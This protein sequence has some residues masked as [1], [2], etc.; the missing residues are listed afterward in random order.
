[1]KRVVITGQG[2]IS[3]L[4]NTADALWEGLKQ[5][6]MVSML[7]QNLMLVKQEFMLRPKLKILIRPTIWRKSNKTH[8]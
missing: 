3:P 4:G 6:K 8:G 1:M 7:S 2:A 5:E